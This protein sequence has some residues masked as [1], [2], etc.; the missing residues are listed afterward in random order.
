MEYSK[1]VRLYENLIKTPKRLEK[2]YFISEFLKE[3]DESEINN[4]INLI[5]GRIY[6][7]WNTK[8]LGIST[9][10]VM[11]AIS[12]ASGS[13]LN[14]IEKEWKNKGDIGD[15][16]ASILNKKK[17]MALFREDLLV[18]D[19]VKDLQKVSE[20]E[21]KGS[22]DLKTK[23]IAKI[24]N[25][26]ESEEARYII[27][28][29][30]EDMRTGASEG[31]L[32]DAICW[33]YFRDEIGI[34]FNMENKSVVEDTNRERYNEI[35]GLVEM[36][37][38]LTNDYGEVAQIA[39]N[40]GLEGLK[41]IGLEIGRP[42]KLM[43][44]PKAEDVK[45]AFTS[46]S[47]KDGLVAF[48]YKYDGFRVQVHKN[49]D[50]V[51]IFTRRLE[52]VTTQFPDV[53]KVVKEH[54][55]ASKCILDAEVVGFDV[56][57]KKYLPFQKI[58]QR[59]RRKY[60]IDEIA[61]KFPVE[62]NVFDIIYSEDRSLLNTEFEERRKILCECINE[63]DKEIL[64][65]KQIVTS[66]EDEASDFYKESLKSGFEGVMAKNLKG[67]Y[68]PGRRVGYG[69]KLKPVMEELDLVI[70]G[71][72]WGTGKRGKWLTSFTIACE[73]ESGELV[74]IGKVGSG[75][76]ELDEEGLSFNMITEKLKP[77][78]ISEKGKD[79]IVK[80]EVIIEI[81]YEEIQTSPSYSSG[82]ALRFPRIVRL[83]D[84]K[85]LDEIATIEQ[86][87]ILFRKQKG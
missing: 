72:E 29:V 69:V 71:A 22:T 7:K 87:E 33:A 15:A 59:I 67:F 39:K 28:T 1:L 84:D 68:K 61:S 81:H 66:S 32:R 12:T 55:K 78:I 65:A 51:R 2:T 9:K 21:G 27:R 52:E 19:F 54:V 34:I 38:D 24:L 46:M 74:E 14:E 36:A 44:F 62:L 3:I 40:K 82:Y 41:T 17:Q 56:E 11:K 26:T 48:E 86:I 49:N 13:S 25:A 8:Q 16:G 42:M 76:K 83:R 47:E 77:L 50:S 63:T 5:Q 37:I 30:L 45:E 80:P 20:V 85:G 31:V 18:A 75:L 79:V 64:C 10:L 4:I 57:T 23:I 58:S 35:V 73:D 6:P 60:D 43:L 70:V 53:I